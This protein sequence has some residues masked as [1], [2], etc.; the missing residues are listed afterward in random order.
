VK[1]RSAVLQMKPWKL[2]CSLSKRHFPGDVRLLFAAWVDGYAL[3]GLFKGNNRESE[4]RRR[5]RQ[6]RIEVRLGADISKSYKLKRQ[7]PQGTNEYE[8]RF[9]G[10][11]YVTDVS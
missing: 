2:N 7:I 6:A 1:Y 3:D 4:S 11:S 10:A 8:F 5:E 9:S